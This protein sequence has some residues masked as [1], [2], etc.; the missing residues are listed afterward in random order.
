MSREAFNAIAADFP[1][2]FRLLIRE[3]VES[4]NDEVRKLAL[5]GAPDGLILLA[6]TQS[7]GR[8]RRG[9]A[10]FS[11]SGESLAFSI[12]VR[13]DE[14][15]ALWPR[16]ALAAG[17]AVAEAIESFNLQPGIKW[18]NDVWLGKRKVAGILVEAGA[19]FAIVGIGLNV[20][21]TT[22]PPEVAEIATSLQL[23]K[24]QPISRADVLASIVRK[25]ANRRHQI[26][27]D[28][29]NLIAAVRLR[30]VLTGNRVSLSTPSGSKIGMIEGISPRGELLF[31][32]PEGLERL[33]QADEVRLLPHGSC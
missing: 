15:I 14:P 13:P 19:D 21:T 17:L 16:L 11:P 2:P 31:R 27:S 3:S 20:N 5:G 25:F 29:E 6:E 7:A 30:C 24:N 22:F 33:I 26:G 28:F 8:G 23:E 1:D 12:L 10:W 9:A 4:T 18:P 32:T